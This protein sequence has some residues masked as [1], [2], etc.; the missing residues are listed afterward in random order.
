MI[1]E[2]TMFTATCDGC[3]HQWENGDGIMA[4][5]EKEHVIDSI[6]DSEWVIADDSKTYC[7]KCWSINDDD[8]FAFKTPKTN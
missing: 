2:I 4:Y 5:T 6:K 1:Q 7:S 8:T 3:G